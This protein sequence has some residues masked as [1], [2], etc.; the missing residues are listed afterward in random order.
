MKIV[1]VGGGTAG[2]LSAYMLTH[3]QPNHSYTV[4]DDSQQSIIGVGEGTTGHFR[5]AIELGTTES[6]FI[7][8]TDA[9]VKLGIEYKDWRKVGEEYYNPI[10]PSSTATEYFDAATYYAV[11]KGHPAD[12]SS[13]NGVWHRNKRYDRKFS[14][15]AYHFDTFKCVQFLKKRSKVRHL[16]K[17]V[18]D[19]NLNETGFIESVVCEDGSI[20][21]GDFFIDASGF[22]RVLI[23]KLSSWRSFKDNLAMN[24]AVPFIED[25]DGGDSTTCT[26]L[27]SGWLWQ[28]PTAKKMGSGYVYCDEYINEDQAIDEVQ[29]HLGRTIT[30]GAAIKFES[31]RVDNIWS[32]NCLAVGLAGSFLEPLQATNIHTTVIEI[33][34]FHRKYLRNTFEDTYSRANVKKFCSE[35]GMMVDNF[36]DFINL[37]YSGERRD[38]K[39]WRMIYQKEHLTDFTRNIIELAGHRG[40][41][42]DDFLY[43]YGSTGVELWIYTLFGM[44]HIPKKTVQKIFKKPMLLDYAKS[45]FKLLS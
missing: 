24:S 34:N 45:K 9:T 13:I 7:N 42:R 15:H 37:H 33:S 4:I 38:S 36:K 22:S 23:G 20:I 10:E 19:C 27:S 11:H 18:V 26:A 21:K 31:G 1:I 6:E 29:K 35:I 3:L 30:P 40:I 39:F 14:T 41:F 44:G 5:E 17:K 12:V 16:D 25:N 8:E 43:Y 28:I 2:W 32:K